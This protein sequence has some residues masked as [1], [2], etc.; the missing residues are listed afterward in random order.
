MSSTICV[1]YQGNDELLRQQREAD[2]RARLYERE[3]VRR[4]ATVERR[5]TGGDII[6]HTGPDLYI[7]PRAKSN[8]KLI[9]NAISY[10]CLAGEPNVSA[11]Q[12]ALAVSAYLTHCVCSLVSCRSWRAA[13][14]V[15]SWYSSEISLD[16][17]SEVSIPIYQTLTRYGVCVR[18]SVMGLL[19]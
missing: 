18:A 8:K 7:A 5:H 6:T 3:R 10:V 16:S 1:G 2:V 14:L 15:M 19:L 17:S 12:R 9:K 4:V 13:L 11:K